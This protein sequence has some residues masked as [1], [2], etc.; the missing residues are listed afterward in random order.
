[1][2]TMNPKIVQ[3]RQE[4]ISQLVGLWIEYL[5]DQGDNPILQYI[6]VAHTEGYSKILHSFLKKEP[7]G[8][9]VAHIDGEI[10]GFV[11]AQKNVYGPNYRMLENIGN[12][13]II[14]TKRSHRH[15]GIASKLLDKALEYLKT[16]NCTVILSETDQQNEASLKL[17]LKHGFK[18]RGNLVTLIHRE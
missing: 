9:L 12:I 13:Q 1:M 15:K 8:F 18:K 16:N 14:H 6:D 2:N 7:E 4:H 17:L 11:I 5:V 3:C 10:V